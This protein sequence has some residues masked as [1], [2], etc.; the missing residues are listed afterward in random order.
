MFRHAGSSFRLDVVD[1]DS[2]GDKALVSPAECATHSICSFNALHTACSNK[3]ESMECQSLSEGALMK[4][5]CK[6]VDKT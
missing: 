4:S 5:F 6:L 3:T 1:V 2:G